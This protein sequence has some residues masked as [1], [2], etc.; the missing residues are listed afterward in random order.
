[1]EGLGRGCYMCVTPAINKS[2]YDT[3]YYNN[4]TLDW[5]EHYDSESCGAKVSNVISLGAF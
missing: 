4:G 5:L 1:M 3:L 2:L